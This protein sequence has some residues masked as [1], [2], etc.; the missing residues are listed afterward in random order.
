MNYFNNLLLKHMFWLLH[1]T[2]LKA[3]RT[4]AFNALIGNIEI[5]IFWVVFFEP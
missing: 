3:H 4:Y 1:E 5:I 2:F